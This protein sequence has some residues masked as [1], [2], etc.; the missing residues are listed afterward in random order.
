MEKLYLSPSYAPAENFGLQWINIASPFDPSGTF[1]RFA[2]AIKIGVGEGGVFIS[3]PRPYDVIIRPILM[4]WDELI[5]ADQQFIGLK[6]NELIPTKL[7]E[8]QFILS[9]SLAERLAEIRDRLNISSN[10]VYD[11]NEISRSNAEEMLNR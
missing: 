5:V 2:W 6:R 11:V 3:G 4:P 8:I 10:L 9:K 7:P 1:N